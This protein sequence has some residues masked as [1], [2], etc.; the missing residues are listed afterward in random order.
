MKPKQVKKASPVPA[1]TESKAQRCEREFQAMLKRNKCSF[2]V[3]RHSRL[4]NGIER[5]QELIFFVEDV[6]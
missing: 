3:E 1:I 6:G 2:Y 4:I 5:S